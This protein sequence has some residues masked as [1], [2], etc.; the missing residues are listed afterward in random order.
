MLAVLAWAGKHGLDALSAAGGSYPA[1]EYRLTAPPTLLGGAYKLRGDSSGR[2]GKG[3]EAEDRKDPTVRLTAAVVATYAGE[4]GSALVVSGF[5]GQIKNPGPTR[6]QILDGG[7][8]SPG[9]TLV[10]PPKEFRPAGF[11]VTVSCQ[12]TRSTAAGRTSTVPMCAWGDGN[13]ASFVALVTPEVSARDPRTVD[14][15]K[16]AGTTAAVRA[17]MRAPLS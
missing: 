13:T 8:T 17:E 1:A 15:R 7:A 5:Y 16:L 9:T 3:L 4:P 10:V 12:V 11:D 2:E 14:L 6:E